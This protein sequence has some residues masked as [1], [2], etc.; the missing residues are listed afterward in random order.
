[1][2]P[3][4]T[5]IT[6]CVTDTALVKKVLSAWPLSFL[7]VDL[8]VTIPQQLIWF[9]YDLLPNENLYYASV[10]IILSKCKSL[11]VSHVRLFLNAKIVYA[12]SLMATW[13]LPFLTKPN[14]WNQ[15][16]HP[17]VSTHAVKFVVEAQSRKAI[18]TQTTLTCSTWEPGY[19]VWDLMR[20]NNGKKWSLQH[21]QGERV[22]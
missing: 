21:N 5:L 2:R 12:V 1:M 14:R 19:R 8:N 20:R 6:V 3:T 13:V 18:L 17:P 22:L 9:Q 15:D 7:Y 4:G 11:F 16:L 10:Y